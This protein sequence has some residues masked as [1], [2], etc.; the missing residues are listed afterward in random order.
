MKGVK[1]GN[2][3]A[4]SSNRFFRRSDDQSLKLLPAR[5]DARR[6][7]D[8]PMMS[9]EMETTEVHSESRLNIAGG[10]LEADAHSLH[11]PARAEYPAR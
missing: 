11:L 8:F 4:K 9:H 7:L 6:G 10:R 2:R 1:P 3:G 5:E